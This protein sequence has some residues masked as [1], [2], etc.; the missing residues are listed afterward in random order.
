MLCVPEVENTGESGGEGMREESQR[1][2]RQK[3]C[4]EG[5]T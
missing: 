1:D 2:W 4:D 5:Q 3:E